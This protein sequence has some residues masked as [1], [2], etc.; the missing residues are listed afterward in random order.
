MLKVLSSKVSAV[1]LYGQAKQLF[2]P[3]C[4]VFILSHHEQFIFTCNLIL[5]ILQLGTN[6]L[7]DQ[8]RVCCHCT[9]HYREVC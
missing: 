4:F 6:P 2:V 1:L 8:R 9:L 3:I 7:Q 5:F